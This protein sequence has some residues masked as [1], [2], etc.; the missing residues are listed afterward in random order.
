MENTDIQN[1]KNLKQ[2]NKDTHHSKPLSRSQIQ[3]A[4]QPIV[5]F[6]LYSETFHFLELPSGAKHPRHISLE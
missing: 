6:K 4:I 5:Q 3:Y 1:F 2:L